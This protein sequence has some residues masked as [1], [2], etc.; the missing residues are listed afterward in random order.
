MRGLEPCN[1]S[2]GVPSLKKK[3][4]R[5]QQQKTSKQRNTGKGMPSH[6]TKSK[7]HLSGKLEKVTY[8]GEKKNTY[9]HVPTIAAISFS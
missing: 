6:V 5:Q 4:Q 3:K 8:G 1:T 2:L 7:E 9:L